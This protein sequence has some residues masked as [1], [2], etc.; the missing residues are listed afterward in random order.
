MAHSRTCVSAIGGQLS[1]RLWQQSTN[2]I[3]FGNH[4]LDCNRAVHGLLWLTN[5][6]QHTGSPTLLRPIGSVSRRS[7]F[8]KISFSTITISDCSMLCLHRKSSLRQ[9]SDNLRKVWNLPIPPNCVP[10]STIATLRLQ[11]F[12]RSLPLHSH[13]HQ[14]AVSHPTLFACLAFSILRCM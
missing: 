9:L 4:C 3:H 11:F 8:C 12:Y 7:A 5:P 6:S 13:P 1:T 2:E 14:L 10:V